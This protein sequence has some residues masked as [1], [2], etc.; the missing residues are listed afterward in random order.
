MSSAADTG[1]LRGL[2][3]GDRAEQ[4]AGVPDRDGP[5]RG[6][7]GQRAVTGER[8][9]GGRGRPA[10]P[11][12]PRAQLPPDPHPHLDPVRAGGAGQHGGHLLQCRVG[13]QLP[14]HVLREVGQHLVGRGPLPVHD[15]VRQQLGPAAQRLEQQCD[16]QRRRGIEE[17]AA[18]V[19]GQR[20]DPHH[21]A[22]VD[23][24]QRRRQQAIPDRAVD[25]DIDLIQPVL[26][27]RDGHRRRDADQHDERH[28]R[29]RD[30]G[31]PGL[32]RLP[33]LAGR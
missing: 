29:I 12:H 9:G 25:D 2:V 14:G 7:L 15:P 30:G 23:R 6:Q 5:R 24:R 32:A 22:H 20:P 4:L 11:G 10:R 18:R 3:H 13:V 33:C 28:C 16:R 17:W 19:T 27:D 26:H 8:D 21:D 1:S 31:Q